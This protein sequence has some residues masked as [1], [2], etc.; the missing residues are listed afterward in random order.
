MGA[1]VR[2][3]MQMQPQNKHNHRVC[4]MACPFTHAI[5]LS[6]AVWA[7]MAGL[8]N[9]FGHVHCVLL[10]PHA[11]HSTAHKLKK[12]KLGTNCACLLWFPWI[13][14]IDCVAVVA[15]CLSAI[16]NQIAKFHGFQ[17]LPKQRIVLCRKAV[18][19]AAMGGRVLTT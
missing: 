15:H 11:C 4:L 18:A 2:Y 13:L 16:Q 17:Q 14:C 8:I 6:C 12:R 19:C 7:N 10:A 5:G 3:K 1:N 9:K